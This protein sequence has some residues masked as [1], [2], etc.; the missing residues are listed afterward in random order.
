MKKVAVTTVLI[1]SL[2]LTACD[3]TVVSKAA[4]T[5]VSSSSVAATSDKTNESVVNTAEIGDETS[6]ETDESGLSH[7]K[8]LEIMTFINSQVDPLNETNMTDD[9]IEE[10]AGEIWKNAEDKF[11]ITENDIYS[12]LGDMDL[13]KEYYSKASESKP[14]SNTLNNAYEVTD[15]DTKINVW[16][17]AQDI[18][19]NNL[20][21]PSSAKF[22]YITDSTILCNG[23]NDYTV[24]GYVDADNSY[25][26]NI[27]SNFTATLTYTQDGYKNGNVIFE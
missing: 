6:T 21:S 10:K 26:A 20:K 17:C 13:T 9:E 11:G 8:K 16:V 12:I 3:S 27:R 5:S 25:G 23:G 7:D 1:L 18:V 15:D 14:D 2:V 4:S 19:S 22:C 24:K